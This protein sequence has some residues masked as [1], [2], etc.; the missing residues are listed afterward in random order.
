M[1]DAFLWMSCGYRLLVAKALDGRFMHG[2]SKPISA[3][4]HPRSAWSGGETV[5]VCTSLGQLN[6][7]GLTRAAGGRERVRVYN[8]AKFQ[9]DH[10]SADRLVRECMTDR[11]IDRII[12][13]VEPHMAKGTPIVCVV[14]HPPF[15]D[16]AAIGVD[17]VGKLKVTN[18]LPIQY[19]AQLAVQLEGEIDNE[20]IQKARVGRTKLTNFP[21]FLCQPS[22]DGAV[23]PDVAYILDVV[24]LDGTLAALRSYIIA[25]GG[26]VAAITVLAHGSGQDRALALTANRWQ[27]LQ[28]MFGAELGSFWEREIGHDAR[29]LTDA[30]GQILVRFGHESV[31]NRTGVP[32]LQ[33]L[34]DRLA[35]AAAKHQ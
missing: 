4:L 8:K 21:R 26:T 27:E 17:S 9:G 35:E 30:E 18:T 22:F 7:G 3:I 5:Y 10:E 11:V 32:L 33:C 25:N 2:G 29:C 15:D 16:I 1:G 28:D 34:R 31:E 14:P 12:D 6:G 20:I 19:A 24:T 13:D 23:R